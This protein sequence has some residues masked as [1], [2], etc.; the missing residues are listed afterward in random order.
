MTE[1]IERILRQL[2]IGANYNGFRITVL[3][4]SMIIENQ[5]RL[6]SVTKEIY[7]DVAQLTH[8]SQ[9]AVE[10]NI[11]TVVSRA[12]NC[13]P[14]KLSQMAGH[15]LSTAPTASEFLDIVSSYIRRVNPPEN[16]APH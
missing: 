11:R 13:N 7:Q 12:W 14:Q 5:D 6:V 15:T 3:A 10:R 16:D 8:Y 2:G 9:T 4:I 1:T